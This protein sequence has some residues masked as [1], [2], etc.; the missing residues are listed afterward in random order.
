MALEMPARPAEIG[1]DL[2]GP[3]PYGRSLWHQSLGATSR[4]R[5]AA[6]L[7]LLACFLQCKG[8]SSAPVAVERGPN[9]RPVVYATDC[10][11]LLPLVRS[12][13]S[14]R[15]R[16]ADESEHDGTLQITT[17][18]SSGKD[19]RLRWFSVL[20]SEGGLCAVQ[21]GQEGILSAS[22]KKARIEHFQRMEAAL[23]VLLAPR[24]AEALAR[25]TGSETHVVVTPEVRLP[26][27][28]TADTSRQVTAQAKVTDGG[29]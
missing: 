5:P 4:M 13:L 19:V 23:L 20:R 14:N 15:M 2:S 1:S 27:S 22:G 11:S 12:V 6:R 18:W 16:I 21:I 28:T 9:L 10:P 8:G 29:R 17:E 24:A 7:V 25:S 3:A 26:M